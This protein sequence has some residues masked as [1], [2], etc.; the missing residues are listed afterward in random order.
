MNEPKKSGP[1]RKK[2]EPGEKKERRTIAINRRVWTE[3]LKVL[4]SISAECERS[5]RRAIKRA[6]KRAGNE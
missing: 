5:L 4:P 1:G 2:M 3:A 6:R